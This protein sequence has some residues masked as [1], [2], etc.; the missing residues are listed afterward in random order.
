MHVNS[1]ATRTTETGTRTEDPSLSHCIKT[2]SFACS[3]RWTW[4]T[5]FHIQLLE[6][7]KMVPSRVCLHSQPTEIPLPGLCSG[8]WQWGRQRSPSAE[9]ALERHRAPT[10]RMPVNREEERLLGQQPLC[11][12]REL[13]A[14]LPSFPAMSDSGRSFAARDFKLTLSF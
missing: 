7:N 6:A 9:T 2:V 13:W 4:L 8:F 10:W 11:P 3:R 5:A 14:G 12:L 1:Q